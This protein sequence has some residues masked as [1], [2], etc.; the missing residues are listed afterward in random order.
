LNKIQIDLS[1]NNLKDKR[2]F[3]IMQNLEKTPKSFLIKH[4]QVGK[5]G[6]DEMS[7]LLKIKNCRLQNLNFL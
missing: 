1:N 6:M 7:K 3:K 4:N 2:T 5:M